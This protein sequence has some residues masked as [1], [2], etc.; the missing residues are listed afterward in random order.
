MQGCSFAAVSRVH[1]GLYTLVKSILSREDTIYKAVPDLAMCGEGTLIATYRESLFHLFHPF[2]RIVVQR[3]E[4][5]GLNWGS[6]QVVDE[7][8]EFAKDGGFNTPRLLALGGGEL[9]LVCDWIPPRKGELNPNTEIFLWRSK[10]CGVSWSSRRGLGIHGHICPGIIRLRSGAI[11]M[12][13][14]RFDSDANTEVTDAF[15]SIDGGH[16]WSSP[17]AVAP[18]IAELTPTEPTFVELESGLLVCYLREDTERRYAYKSF[19]RDGG[20]TWDGIYPTSL[21]ICRGRPRAGLLESG[22]VAIT[23]GFG[24]SPRLL[25][26]HVETQ[27]IAADPQSVEHVE[28]GH[29]IQAN[30]RRFFVDQDRS[31]HPDGA[32]SGWVQLPDGDLYVIQYIVDDAPMAHI[33]SYRIS[34]DDWILSPTGELLQIDKIDP[35]ARDM[36]QYE[37]DAYIPYHQLALQASSELYKR[38]VVSAR[39]RKGR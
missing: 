38:S 7:C 10:D 18:T 3:S 1:G 29:H 5:G 2:S 14:S 21:V 35:V 28:T 4:D 24:V 22:E 16:T 36:D 31:I 33:R 39:N 12:G 15:R 13:A 8:S 23:Y 11:V 37:P 20:A 17:S 34:R 30:Y 32:Y 9:L 6:K 25:V 27:E 19:S 26:L